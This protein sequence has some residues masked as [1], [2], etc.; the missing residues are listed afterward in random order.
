MWL[1]N[2]DDLELQMEIQRGDEGRKYISYDSKFIIG[3]MVDLVKDIFRT[4]H[5]IRVVENKIVFWVMDNVGGHG[6]N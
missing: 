3:V 4:R 5:S 2:M 1:L 6:I